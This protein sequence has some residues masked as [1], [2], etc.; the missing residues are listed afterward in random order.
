MNKDVASIKPYNI[1]NTKT[2]PHQVPQS[3]IGQSVTFSSFIEYK[4]PLSRSIFSENGYVRYVQ[5]ADGQGIGR[6]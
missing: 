5:T 4:E 1:R 2:L 3:A 6:C